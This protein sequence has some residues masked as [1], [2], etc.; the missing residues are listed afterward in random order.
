LVFFIM[1]FFSRYITLIFFIE[2]HKN[3]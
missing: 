2:V 3:G 1:S